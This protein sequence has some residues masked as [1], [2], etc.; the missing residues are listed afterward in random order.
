MA[1]SMAGSS[2]R[3]ALVGL[4]AL[5]FAAPAAAQDSDGDGVPNTADAYPCD[6]TLAAVAYAPARGQSGVL[7]FEDLWPAAGDLD[8]NDATLAYH[9]RVASDGTGQPRELLLVVDALALGGDLNNGLG[10]HLPVPRGAVASVARRID[11]GPWAPLALSAADAELTVVLSENLRELFDGRGG[12]INSR[13]SD[14]R[15]SGRR[16]EVQVSFSGPLTLPMGQAPF[17]LFLRRTERTGLEIHRVGY[18]GT[19]GMETALFGSA[20]DASAPGRWF[21]DQRGLPFALEVPVTATYP[22]EG[23]AVSTLFPRLLEFAASG[24]TSAQD[25][26]LSPVSA[27]A[28]RDV[29]GLGPLAPPALPAEIIDGAC[30]PNAFAAHLLIDLPFDGG[31][32]TNFGRLAV[33]TV[34]A[35][36]GAQSGGADE[37]GYAFN[38]AAGSRYFDHPDLSVGDSGE[39]TF[40]AWYRGTQTN[41]SANPY[42]TGVL[43]FGDPAGS[44]WLGLG[45]D[46]GRISIAN[47]RFVRG[48]RDVADG[49]WHQLVFVRRGLTWDGYV[50]GVR[51]IAGFLGNG[52]PGKQYIRTIGTGYGYGGTAAPTQ[53]D[54]IQVYDLALTPEQ[55]ALADDP[56][57]ALTCNDGVMSGLEAGVDCGGPYCTPCP[58]P[59]LVDLTFEQGS[60]VNAGSA[61][62]AVS[63]ALSFP[64]SGGVAGGGYATGFSASADLDIPDLYVGGGGEHTFITWYRGTQTNTSANPYQT[65]VLIFGDPANSVWIGL[66]VDAGRAAIAN[67]GFVRGTTHVADGQW[68]QLAF[69]RSGNTWD[70]YVD[71]QREIAGWLANGSPG[72]QYIRSIG[73]G[74][75]YSGTASPTALDQV[76]IIPTALTAGQVRALFDARR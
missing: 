66:G 3:P 76:Q 6:P 30:L 4:V 67:G 33:T 63:A 9:Y 13:A 60:A 22:L 75:P 49:Q 45:V 42:Q 2:P 37:G 18:P 56:S 48:T 71:G 17:D 36:A 20:S 53:L 69:V 70:V 54:G 74:Y 40:V 73:R 51:E 39:H 58:V 52:S 16:L 7:L 27:A 46:A 28:Y 64:S 15:Q 10:L 62:V 19:A 8:F 55:L 14:A 21:V 26:Y 11:G 32:L 47:G 34:G 5:L 65:G 35:V 24:G 29:A 31:A 57:L 23:V 1:I 25:F 41:S 50:D 43:I 59:P 38:F 68:H 72:N 44:V 61:N 12:P